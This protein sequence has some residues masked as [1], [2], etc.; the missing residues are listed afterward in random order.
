MQDRHSVKT[1]KK[2]FK[3]EETG[4]LINGK[5]DYRVIITDKNGNQK[6]YWKSK[7]N[8]EDVK[9]LREKY[10]YAFPA[11]KLYAKMPPPPP[12]PPAPP[13]GNM[14]PPPAPPVNKHQGPPPPPANKLQPPPPPPAPP[15]KSTVAKARG[16]IYTPTQLDADSSIA[17]NKLPVVLINGKVYD[18]KQPLK[19]GYQLMIDAKGG[20]SVV[21]YNAEELPDAI[22][23]YG[24]NA[25]NGVVF[26]EGVTSVTIK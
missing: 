16:L 20:A 9:M 5:T 18:F 2:G 6:E 10:G 26:A 12:M 25:K 23:K 19:K 7:A 17:Y 24:P 3:Y 13:K 4:Y 21:Q 15:T 11:M 1:S 22:K 14:P 8:A